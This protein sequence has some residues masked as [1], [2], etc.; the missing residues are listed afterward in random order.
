MRLE[1]P[2]SVAR[3]R[4]QRYQKEGLSLMELIH[5][6]FTFIVASAITLTIG[7][8]LA[9]I[10]PFLVTLG[11]S[12]VLFA[13]GM[14]RLHRTEKNLFGPLF[15]YEAL[16]L[17]RN[18]RTVWLRVGYA[19]SLLF[20]LYLVH[21]SWNSY[22]ANTIVVAPGQDSDGAGMSHNDL[23]KLGETFATTLLLMQFLAVVVLTPMYVA[24]AIAN[25][26][27]NG[28]IDFLFA[29]HLHDHEI[30]FGNLLARSLAIAA[31]TLTG[32]PVIALIQFWGGIDFRIFAA[33]F[34]LTGTTILLA[35]SVTIYTSVTCKSWISALFMS[36][37]ITVGVMYPT[38]PLLGIMTTT[39]SSTPGPGAG[40]GPA[41]VGAAT[42][43]NTTLYQVIGWAML[44]QGLVGTFFLWQSVRRLR[45]PKKT[46]TIHPSGRKAT[47]GAIDGA[48]LPEDDFFR[49]KPR[50]VGLNPIW[51]R[52]TRI[53]IGGFVESVGWISFMGL[54]LYLG[55]TFLAS[56]G[57]LLQ[58]IATGPDAPGAFDVRDVD[59]FANPVIKYLVLAAPLVCIGLVSFHLTRTVAKEREG[60][61]MD[62]LL[63]I[64]IERRELLLNKWKAS[65]WLFRIP[66]MTCAVGWLLGVWTLA[67]HPVSC[68]LLIVACAIHLLF[69]SFYS[70]YLSVIC[71]TPLR[72]S[73]T[74]GVT[75]LVAIAGSYLFSGTL[76]P[77]GLVFN[78]MESWQFLAFSW[79]ETISLR[80][81]RFSLA[82][83]LLVVVGLLVYS[84]LGA[85]FA[86]LS[87]W[88][89][90]SDPFRLPKREPGS[91]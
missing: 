11:I 90:N 8:I 49:T 80:P 53:N 20:V 42:S 58:A 84:V 36:Y 28:T 1:S 85:G 9:R 77:V 64:P 24:G 68:L 39:V 43:L 65:F 18:Y 62:N 25:E 4:P 76:G 23:A 57:Y 73:V 40:G 44:Y 45:D 60:Q 6:G 74:L 56:L 22:Y 33:G 17:A 70:L 72:S 67:L 83:F 26:R 81:D 13:Y 89:F 61:L 41:P 10:V 48:R 27:K 14:F 7:L 15:Y 87:F 59:A 79:Y 75:V 12:L 88:E 55:Y 31:V 54:L 71:R 50:P 46:N 19:F 34:V 29:S 32:L 37:A 91:E 3:H 51:W 2:R 35:A 86:F 82:H 66:L 52:E 38:T 47:P 21:M 63:V 78:P 69:F 5:S 30:I 16:R